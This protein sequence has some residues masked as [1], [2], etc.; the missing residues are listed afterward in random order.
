M[1][2]QMIKFILSFIFLT[3]IS[4]AGLPLTTSRVSGDSNNVTTFNFQFPNFTGTHTGTTVS[5]GVNNIAGGGTNNGSLGVTA[6]GVIYSDGSKLMNTGAGTSGFALTSNGSSAPSWTSV[7]TNPMTTG[8]DLIY[9]GASGVPTRLANGTTG[10]VLTSAGGTAAPAWGAITSISGVYSSTYTPTVAGVANVDSVSVPS[11]CSYIG[12]G[13]VIGPISCRIVVDCTAAG[14][15]YTEFTATLPVSTTQGTTITGVF[16]SA[17]LREVGRVL[18]SGN[19]AS[20]Q[21]LCNT[22][23]ATTRTFTF[24]YLVP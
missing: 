14:D 9:G 3:S 11:A 17:T 4:F 15:I 20:I 23:G 5:L 22:A 6:G 1:G 2:D 13:N 7:L 8:G 10:Q 16:G 21:F 24:S 19:L 18:N 12:L